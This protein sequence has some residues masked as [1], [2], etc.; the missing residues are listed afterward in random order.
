[1]KALG[2]LVAIAL[3][4]ALQTTLSRFIVGG[5]VAVDLVLVAVIATAL[6]IGPVGGMLAGSA[7]GLIQDALASG[8]IG[9]GGL[10]KTIVGFLAGRVRSAVHRDRG[11]ATA[12]DFCRGYGAAR[13]RVHGPL[14]TPEPARVPVAVETMAAQALG[15]ALVGIVAF[16]IIESLPGLVERRRARRVRR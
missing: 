6:T 7:A 2:V 1:V 10:A 11:A 4:L 3:S 9:I 12:G 5:S 13:G 8:V 16:G 15:N 14:F